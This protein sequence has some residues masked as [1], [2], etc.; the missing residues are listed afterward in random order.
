[1]ITY[2]KLNA[3]HDR[4]GNPRRIFCVFRDGDMIATVDE[5]Y[6]SDHFVKKS[7]PDAK[8]MGEFATTPKQ[9][10]ELYNFHNKE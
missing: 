2:L 10:R 7:W 5:E 3:G 8:Y 1:M 6:N 9:Y 4:N